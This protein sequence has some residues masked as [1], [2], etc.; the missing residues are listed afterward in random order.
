M[1]A[2]PSSYYDLETV[3]QGVAAGEHRRII[4]G[5]WDEM[6]AHQLDFLISRGLKPEHRLLDIG[7]G[8]LR[9]GVRAIAWLAPGRYF[10]SDLS[11]ALI[12]AGYAAEL[13]DALRA[14]APR[15]HFAVN[16][17]FDFGFLPE[18]VDFAIAQSVFTHLPLNHM[19]RCLARLKGRMKPG[20]Q[21]LFTYFECP[22]EADLF[23][24]F[25]HPPAGVVSHDDRD[26]YH[27]RLTDLEWAARETGW[28]FESIGDWGHLRGQRI[29][30]FR[31]P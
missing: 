22:P 6:G 25:T 3:A 15:D 17:D 31:H 23:Q 27:Y 7:C 24:P 8:S 30:A 14:K 9:L 4:G 29:A 10:G 19:R 26:P 1:S 2:G 12:D 11:Q 20:G 28:D 5:L 21:A 18:P 13:D 16:D